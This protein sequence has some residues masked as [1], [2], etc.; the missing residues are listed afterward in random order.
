MHMPFDLN[1]NYTLP[2]RP[3]EAWSH[4]PVYWDAV[5]HWCTISDG[6]EKSAGMLAVTVN[7]LIGVTAAPAD[8]GSDTGL[9][10]LNGTEFD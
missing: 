10:R 6:G 2:K 1:Q 5:Q 7:A 9:V 4:S 3:D 8:I